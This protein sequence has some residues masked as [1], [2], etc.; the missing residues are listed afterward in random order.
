M[1]DKEYISR[2]VI[3]KLTVS[4]VA[5]NIIAEIRDLLDSLLPDEDKFNSQKLIDYAEKQYQKKYGNDEFIL[6]SDV[7]PRLRILVDKFKS[8]NKISYEEYKKF[9]VW[10]IEIMPNKLNRKFTVYDILS[11]K[12][13]ECFKNS[14]KKD[15]EIIEEKRTIRKKQIIRL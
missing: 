15:D 4:G 2:V 14:S 3:K 11:E 6:E 1:I 9:V 5:E 8:K 10:L 13:Y 7:S 12:F